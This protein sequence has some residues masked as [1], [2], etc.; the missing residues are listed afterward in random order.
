MAD[1][2]KDIGGPNRPHD[3]HDAGC[4]DRLGAENAR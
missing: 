3:A 1:V 2:K 4:W